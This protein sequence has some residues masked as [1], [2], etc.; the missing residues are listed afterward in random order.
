MTFSKPSD[1][2]LEITFIVYAEWDDV[3][4]GILTENEGKTIVPQPCINRAE[5]A[6]LFRQL[7]LGI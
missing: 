3:E 7:V 5:M 4:E 6:I 1:R 2:T